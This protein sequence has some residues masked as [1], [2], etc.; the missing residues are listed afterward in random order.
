MIRGKVIN[1]EARV[2]VIF[3]LPDGSQKPVEC[4]L[5]TG[6]AGGLALPQDVIDDLALPLE[7]EINTTLANGTKFLANVH[8]GAILWDGAEINAAVYVMG[9]SRLIGSALLE[10]KQVYVDFVEN[11]DVLIR[12]RQ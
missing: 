2:A 8:S 7:I 9:E 3:R 4:V 6:F 1:M 12:Q 10:N 11:G 5:D